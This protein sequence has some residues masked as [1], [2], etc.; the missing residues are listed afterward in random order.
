M[1]GKRYVFVSFMRVEPENPEP[2][3]LEEAK[4]EL[5]HLGVLHPKG[6]FEIEEVSI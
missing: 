2:L 6:R 3:T 4:K 1:K 5:E